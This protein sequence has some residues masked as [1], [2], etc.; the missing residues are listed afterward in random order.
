MNY[1][2]QLTDNF[3]KEFKR[4][5][6]KYTSLKDDLMHLIEELETNPNLGTALGKDIY[7]IRL[8]IKS[9]GKGKSGGARVIT[10][11]Q[12]DE[13]TVILISIYN[14]GQKDTITDKEIK[15]LL[16]NL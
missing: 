10:Y 16:D 13:K 1:N 2:V 15:E 14:K 4:I 3:K 5:H 9:K 8:S 11:I 12:I 6:K 7:K